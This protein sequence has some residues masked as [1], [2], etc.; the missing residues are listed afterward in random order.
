MC[1]VHGSP[2]SVTEGVLS[3][4]SE[5]KMQ[6]YLTGVDEGIVVTGHTHLPLD[7]VSGC[8]HILNPAAV[9][10]P[11][12]GQLT[13]SHMLLDGDAG[14]WRP[15]FRRVPFDYEPIFQECERQRFVVE[16]GLTEHLCVEAVPT[17][18]PQHSFLRWRRDVRRVPSRVRLVGV[19]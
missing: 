11:R 5:E 2:R 13:A 18:R 1:I 12:D 9:G 16:C 6:V 3:N 10:L 7:R 17:A 8:W 15:T 19:C 14:G 4:T